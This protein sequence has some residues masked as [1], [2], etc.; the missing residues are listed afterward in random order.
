M[1][2]HSETPTPGQLSAS[3]CRAE[4]PEKKST[5]E[6]S[7]TAP[8]PLLPCLSRPP[9]PRPAQRRPHR[10]AERTVTPPAQRTTRPPGNRARS[11]L[12]DTIIVRGN[13]FGLLSRR[14]ILHDLIDAQVRDRSAAARLL[15]GKPEALYVASQLQQGLALP[16]A[17]L[18][19]RGAPKA[20]LLDDFLQVG[21]PALELRQ[22]LR[23][24]V[25]ALVEEEDTLR[26]R[27]LVCRAVAEG[28]CG[29]PYPRQ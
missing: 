17:K 3:G 4:F 15:L 6:R 5:I 18:F 11:I 29:A 22:Q 24:A 26:G 10:G 7:A 16:A 23:L 28:V 14:D 20:K 2:P 25:D 9:P 19:G 21:L 27:P 8:S 13:L 1:E 12:L